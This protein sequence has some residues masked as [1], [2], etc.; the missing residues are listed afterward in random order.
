MTVV[1][2][3]Q[4]QR[5]STQSHSKTVASPPTSAKSNSVTI[6]PQLVAK[7]AR[8]N[9]E[10]KDL[11][12]REALRMAGSLRQQINNNSRSQLVIFKMMHIIYLLYI[13]LYIL[14]FKHLD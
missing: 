10:W 4:S 6:S 3:G 12:Y 1:H 2:S 13:T 11:I 5:E 7:K 14:H 9:A 8:I